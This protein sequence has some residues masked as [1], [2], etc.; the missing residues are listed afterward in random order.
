ME[1]KKNRNSVEWWRAVL[2]D[3]EDRKKYKENEIFR[4]DNKLCV[5]SINKDKKMYVRKS[6]CTKRTQYPTIPKKHL[7]KEMQ[8]KWLKTGKIAK[9]QQIQKISVL[10]LILETRHLFPVGTINCSWANKIQYTRRKCTRSEFLVV[11]VVSLF[12]KKP[13]KPNHHYC[14]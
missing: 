11:V 3:W 14:R 10:I 7:I 9:R 12:W 1:Q 6:I 4:Y 13:P 8:R 2:E 5:R